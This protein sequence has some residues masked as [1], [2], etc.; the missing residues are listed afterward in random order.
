MHS[1]SAKEGAEVLNQVFFSSFSVTLV[2]FTLFVQKVPI[3][4]CCPFFSCLPRIRVDNKRGRTCGGSNSKSQELVVLHT[5]CNIELVGFSLK[6]STVKPLPKETLYLRKISL[7]P[8]QLRDGGIQEN[9]PLN[10]FSPN[11]PI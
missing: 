6:Y 2:R 9:H 11:F 1:E 4:R 5:Y 3:F 10:L 7:F 8:F